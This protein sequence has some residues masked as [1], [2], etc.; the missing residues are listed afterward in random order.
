M[1]VKASQPQHKQGHYYQKQLECKD[2]VIAW[3]HAS[4]F[5]KAINLMGKG[6]FPRLLD[7][8]CGDGTMV[9]MISDR[10]DECWGADIAEDQLEDCR[11]RLSD[12]QNAH[13]CQ[14]NELRSP[15]FEK[16]FDL[17]LC[18]ETLEHCIDETATHVIND[19][20]FLA[21]PN[22]RILI[23]VP[24]EI[25]PTFLFKLV[26]RTLAA[27]RGLSNYKHYEGYTFKNALRMIFATKATALERPAYGP[28]GS[29]HHSHY[30]FNWKQMRSKIDQTLKVE[31]TTFS[32]L[33]LF[34]GLV[35]SQAWFICRPR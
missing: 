23:S 11:K 22:S 17:I 31:K 9:T 32:P 13:F 16:S 24:I 21:K 6:P 27:W 26:I 4:R 10:A 30:G 33:P 20:A 18:M 29:Q 3:S 7:Y 28:I 1:T 12:F 25:G 19:L 2:R 14:V 8:G 15:T 34:G 35:S 5:T